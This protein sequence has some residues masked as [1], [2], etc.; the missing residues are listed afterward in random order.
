MK[1]TGNVLELGCS[2]ILAVILG[3]VGGIVWFL[4]GPETGS[5]WW[6]ILA[7]VFVSWVVAQAVVLRVLRVIS[8]FF[9]ITW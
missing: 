1:Q 3:I 6:V 5:F 2:V 7:I 4:L 9:H 8:N